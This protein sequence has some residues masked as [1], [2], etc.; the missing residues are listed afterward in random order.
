MRLLTLVC[1]VCCNV[2]S[3]GTA[4]SASTSGS[5]SVAAHLRNCICVWSHLPYAKHLCWPR[6]NYPHISSWR[7]RSRI[8][9][10]KEL[11]WAMSDEGGYGDN[12]RRTMDARVAVLEESF[13]RVERRLDI[14]GERTHTLVN[15]VNASTLLQEEAQEQ[16]STMLKSLDNVEKTVAT[17]SADTLRTVLE[18]SHHVKMCDKRSGRLEKIGLALIGSVLSVLGLL[19]LDWVRK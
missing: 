4:S 5:T 14:V 12:S 7:K 18:L 17:L 9:Q 10:K 3:T 8:N 19:L 1:E 6:I 13:K 16:R 11:A 2:Q 15:S